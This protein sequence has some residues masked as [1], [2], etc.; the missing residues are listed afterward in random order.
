MGFPSPSN[1]MPLLLDSER[2]EVSVS[3]ACRARRIGIVKEFCECETKNNA[4]CPFKFPFG[5][6]TF[7]RHPHWPKIVV[8]ARL[9]A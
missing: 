4:G 8:Q 2:D 5:D 9:Q 6:A 3:P 7:C 1:E